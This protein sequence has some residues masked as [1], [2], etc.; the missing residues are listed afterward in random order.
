MR[1]TRWDVTNGTLGELTQNQLRALVRLANAD[2]DQWRRQARRGINHDSHFLDTGRRA[3]QL[4]VH[5]LPGT[6]I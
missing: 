5:T 1:R 2:F 6:Q 4:R 3:D